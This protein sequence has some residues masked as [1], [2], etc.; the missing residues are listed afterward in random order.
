MTTIIA[1]SSDDSDWPPRWYEQ[2]SEEER[3]AL[4]DEVFTPKFE[5]KLDRI[6]KEA[7]ERGERGDA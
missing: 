7:R 4:I 1:P 2:M 6:C 5:T 3:I